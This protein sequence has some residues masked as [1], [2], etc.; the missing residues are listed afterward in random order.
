MSTE[1]AAGEGAA[2]GKE[3]LS[4]IWKMIAESQA[5]DGDGKEMVSADAGVPLL[6]LLST[7]SRVLTRAT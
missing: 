2:G 5:L 6:N 1:Q 3:Q 7:L 4:A